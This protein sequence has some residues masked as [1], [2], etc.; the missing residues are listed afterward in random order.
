MREL[1]IILAVG[2]SGIAI[3]FTF[4]Y[5]FGRSKKTKE[6]FTSKGVKNV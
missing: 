3:G 4:G 2:F 5:V 1:Y 6:H